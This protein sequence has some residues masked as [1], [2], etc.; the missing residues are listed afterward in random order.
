LKWKRPPQLW[1]YGALLNRALGHID[2]IL[3]PSRFCADMLA[4]RGI[5]GEMRVLPDFVPVPEIASASTAPHPKPYF[6]FVGRLEKIKGLQDIL[7]LF[8]SPGDYDLLVV[9]SGPHE[10][11]LRSMAAQSPRVHF[12]GWKSPGQIGQYFRHALA[13]VVPSATYETFGVVVIEAYAHALPVIARDLGPLPEVVR[14]GGLLYHTQAELSAHLDRLAGDQGLREQLARQGH[15]S[16][17]EKW[18]AEAHLRLYEEFI[19]E[20]RE[21]KFGKREPVAV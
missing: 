19:S 13:L 7:P 12:L 16:Y 17:L 3:T 14:Q 4:R 9:G 11:K 8:Q 5:G 15:Q 20:V 21:Q 1:R 10:P 2:R 6:L 18:T